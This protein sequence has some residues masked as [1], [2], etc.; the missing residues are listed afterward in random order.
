[1]PGT[2]PYVGS[3]VHG[4]SAHAAAIDVMTESAARE[5]RTIS[6]LA[7]DSPSD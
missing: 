1:M 4:R 6:K 2:M 3:D 7:P 5:E